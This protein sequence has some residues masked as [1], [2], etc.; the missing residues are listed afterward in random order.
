MQEYIVSRKNAGLRIDQFLKEEL[1][2]LPSSLLYKT[3]RKKDVKVNE[4]RVKLGRQLTVN[5]RVQIYI[6]DVWLDNL[7]EQYYQNPSEFNIVYE[8]TNL[9][10]VDKKQGVLCHSDKEGKEKTLLERV[11]EYLL[12]KDETYQYYPEL[13]NRIDRNTGGIVIIAKNPRS[14]QIIDEK[15]RNHE[16]KKYYF[17]VVNGVPQKKSGRIENQ[18]FKDSV[19]RISYITENRTKK[20]RTAITDYKVIAHKGNISLLECKLITGRTH[21]I[22]AQLANM[23]HAIIGDNKYGNKSLNRDAFEKRQLLYS[24][25]VEFNFSTDAGDLRYLKNQAFSVPSI[26]FVEKYF[27]EIKLD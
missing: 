25:K 17:C 3:I 24:T 10:L 12:Y 23:G 4:V 6:S 11:Y 14:K 9:I 27:P 16:I 26:N 13:C 1:P 18:I 8:D 22:R 7:K 5:D 21:Q 19:R 2:Y 15:I 20:T